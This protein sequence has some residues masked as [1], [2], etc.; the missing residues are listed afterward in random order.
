[1]RR[2]FILNAVSFW[3]RANELCGLP[4]GVEMTDPE[5]ICH[6]VRFYIKK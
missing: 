2:C 3:I 1:M 6:F 4:E 5:F